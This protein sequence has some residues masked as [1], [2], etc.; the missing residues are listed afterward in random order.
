MKHTWAIHI[1]TESETMEDAGAVIEMFLDNGDLEDA[2]NEY[3]EDCGENVRVVS[4][5][6]IGEY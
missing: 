4:A 2:I 3:A 6:L 5:K 1:V